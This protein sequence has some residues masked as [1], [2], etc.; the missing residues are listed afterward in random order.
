M[1]QWTKDLV[2]VESSLAIEA[3]AVGS[4][5]LDIDQS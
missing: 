3:K 1:S 4:C 5:V 2:E